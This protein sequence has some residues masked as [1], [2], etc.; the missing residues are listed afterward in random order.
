M[1]LTV[2][3]AEVRASTS[4][5]N[6]RFTACLGYAASP[7]AARDY[8]ASIRREFPD[9]THHVPAFVIGGGNSVTEFCSDD[10]EP[11]GTSGR[12]V[13]AVLKGS[14][15]SNA[16]LV[17]VRYFGGT[18]L[19]TGGLVQAYSDAARAVTGIVRKARLVDAFRAELDVPYTI[20]DRV[21]QLVTELGGVTDSETFAEIVRLELT[22][23][24]DSWER[25]DK[26]IANLSAGAVRP[27][28]SG[29]IAFPVAIDHER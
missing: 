15:L 29:Q 13:L 28:Q 18:L 14:G 27:R 7:S 17:V 3:M 5:S 21:R 12:P 16:V 11:S 22:I 2:P 9:A 8:I 26:A 25:F 1:M 10:G 23:P 4:V 6:S 20:F 24:A 19:G